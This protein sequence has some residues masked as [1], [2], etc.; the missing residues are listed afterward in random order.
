MGCLASPYGTSGWLKVN[1]Y[2]DPPKNLFNYPQWQIQHQQQWIPIQ[3][4]AHR[5]H[6]N[7]WVVKL[8]GVDDRERAKT[9]TN[10]NIAIFQHE[11]PKLEKGNYYWHELLGI[12]VVTKD[13]VELGKITEFLETPAN[14]VIVCKNKKRYLLP[15]TKEVVLSIDPE[16]RRMLVD[17]DPE[18]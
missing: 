17:W 1:S 18:F 10:D 9:F 4:T 8:S 3:I 15:Y 5:P 2:T 11:L 16:M 14:D 13:N 6:G 12:T 7:T